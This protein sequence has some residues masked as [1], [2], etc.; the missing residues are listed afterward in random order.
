M[1]EVTARHLEYQY[2]AT[3][4]PIAQQT[5]HPLYHAQKGSTAQQQTPCI[6]ALEYLTALQDQLKIP[7]AQL[8]TT[9]QTQLPDWRVT[10]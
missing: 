1:P 7:N 9:A 5:L 10:E 6:C 4:V 8:D 3:L 2:S